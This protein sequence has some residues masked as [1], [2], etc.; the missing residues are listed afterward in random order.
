MCTIFSF[1]LGLT[2]NL[3]WK[4]GN[5]FMVVLDMGLDPYYYSVGFLKLS[6]G[7]GRK[8]EWLYKDTEPYK[9]SSSK[10]SIGSCGESVFGNPRRLPL[11]FLSN[12]FK[13]KK[14]GVAVVWQG[15]SSLYSFYSFPH[16]KLSMLSSF[17]FLF[18]SKKYWITGTT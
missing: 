4:I 1:F 18:I 9:F 16:N 11:L 17:L 10:C 14:D 6:W 5:S 12:R 15:I 2:K 8:C 7:K 3:I 13:L